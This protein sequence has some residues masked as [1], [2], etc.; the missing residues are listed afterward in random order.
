MKTEKTPRYNIEP[1]PVG[2]K[3]AAANPPKETQWIIWS[4]KHH[5]WWGPKRAGYF[6][7]RH[8]AGRYAEVEAREILAQ[9]NQHGGD[10]PGSSMVED[11]T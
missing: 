6:R 10:I 7:L 1:F 2:D 3:T 4:I 11:V 9:S 5:A 8:L